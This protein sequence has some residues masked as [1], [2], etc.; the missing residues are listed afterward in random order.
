MEG[1][2]ARAGFE[3]VSSQL[4]SSCS[5]PS[6]RSA[7]HQ[8]EDRGSPGCFSDHPTPRCRDTPTS[9]LEPGR[10]LPTCVCRAVERVWLPPTDL[11][12]SLGAGQHQ[13]G[14][15]RLLPD[16][17]RPAVLLGRSGAGQLEGGAEF[18]ALAM[19]PDLLPPSEPGRCEDRREDP[20]GGVETDDY[21][22]KFCMKLFKHT[23][24]VETRADISVSRA[25]LC[26]TLMFY[27][28][29]FGYI[30]SVSKFL[31]HK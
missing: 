18:A 14:V 8:G 3:P 15:D 13:A 7:C 16:P 26:Q 22:D 30:L 19:G 27:T 9:P 1:F 10:L 2:Q 23:E 6:P 28:N 29:C 12:S 5:L 17:Q 4:Q 20:P 31:R 21:F 24:K 11:G 25:Q